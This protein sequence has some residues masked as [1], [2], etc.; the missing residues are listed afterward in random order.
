MNEKRLVR[1]Q[2]DRM[3]F[4]VAAGIAN[5]LNIDPVLVRLIFVLLTLTNGGGLL[6]YILLALLMPED[7]A[8]AKANGFSDE[9][10]I[11]KDAV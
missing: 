9:E 4:G 6:V 5:Y 10:I 7:Q 1:S 2:S 11:I 3:F 8:T